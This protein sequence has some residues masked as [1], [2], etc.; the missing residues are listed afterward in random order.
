MQLYEKFQPQLTYN[1]V[2]QIENESKKAKPYGK[3]FA[4]TENY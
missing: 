2:E 4:A 3:I 1:S